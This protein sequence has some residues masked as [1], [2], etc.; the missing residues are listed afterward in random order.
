M[1]SSI[2][3]LLFLVSRIFPTMI[4]A[5]RRLWQNKDSFNRHSPAIFSLTKG[6]RQSEGGPRQAACCGH[7]T[8]EDLSL[9]RQRS[10]SGELWVI[11]RCCQLPS[12]FFH[13]GRECFAST[14]LDWDFGAWAFRRAVLKRPE[15]RSPPSR[16]PKGQ[17]CLLYKSLI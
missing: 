1:R 12:W 5:W 4:L 15:S 14:L 10:R 17:G 3:L 7:Q 9:L 13:G 16:W 2:Y 11:E 8:S 6:A